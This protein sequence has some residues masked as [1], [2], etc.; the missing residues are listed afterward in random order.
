MSANA[1]TYCVEIIYQEYNLYN[2]EVASVVIVTLE[3]KSLLIV[4]TSKVPCDTFYTD[5]ISEAAHTG[6][7]K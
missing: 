5:S 1:R 2:Q 6:L 7:W 3:P 4:F